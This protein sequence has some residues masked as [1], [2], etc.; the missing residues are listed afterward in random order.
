M[1]LGT[2]M[3]V[4]GILFVIF[5]FSSSPTE[6]EEQDASEIQEETDLP[7]DRPILV[8]E[9]QAKSPAPPPLPDLTR[10]PQL[11][12]LPLEDILKAAEQTG[13]N[14]QEF[15]DSIIRDCRPGDDACQ[16][17][18]LYQYI[19]DAYL[20]RPAKFSSYTPT[21]AVDMPTKVKATGGDQAILLWALLQRHRISSYLIAIPDHLYAAACGIPLLS[22]QAYL[23]DQILM[24]TVPVNLRR[25]FRIAPGQY[26]LVPLM[27]TMPTV[28]RYHLFSN[29]PIS[30]ELLPSH[31]DLN[32]MLAGE[33]YRRH[34]CSQ[35]DVLAGNNL[36][37]VEPGF[38]MVLRNP[39]D[40]K[41]EIDALIHY[42]TKRRTR[43]KMPELTLY[44]ING[45]SCLPLDPTLAKNAYPGS[46]PPQAAKQAVRLAIGANGAL[47]E[48]DAHPL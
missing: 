13:P 38:L 24:Q 45:Q 4:A 28:L 11:K 7:A 44:T 48:V 9:E 19:H 29:A 43:Q 21:A 25:I 40:G 26:T 1:I 36:C 2:A 37:A 17:F 20:Y 31:D 8:N 15:A 18:A 3:F 41:A 6:N 33:S 42:Q 39:G 14:L 34:S 35:G 16:L 12:D 47:Y 27:L 10:Y 5:S 46:D 23:A 30:V 22:S 32:A